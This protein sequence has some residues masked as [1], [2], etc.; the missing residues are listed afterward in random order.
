MVPVMANSEQ[1]TSNTMSSA[2]SA[3]D[4]LPPYIFKWHTKGNIAAM[5]YEKHDP[6]KLYFN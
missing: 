4:I 5:E 6:S 3:F 2:F 1:R